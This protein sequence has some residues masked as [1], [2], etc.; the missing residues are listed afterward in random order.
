MQRVEAKGEESRQRGDKQENKGKKEDMKGRRNA[1]T[2]RGNN[3]RKKRT[4]RREQDS[5]KIRE[6]GETNGREEG[7]EG[8][9]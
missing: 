1:W 4:G 9:M 2:G 5:K 3:V 6:E 8:I 7:K